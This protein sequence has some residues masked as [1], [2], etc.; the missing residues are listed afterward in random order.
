MAHF[1]SRLFTDVASSGIY[2]RKMRFVDPY[3]VFTERGF[4]TVWDCTDPSNPVQKDRE[5]TLANYTHDAMFVNGTDIHQLNG[6]NRFYYVYDMSD[7]TNLTLRGAISTGASNGS[8]GS[9]IAKQGNYVYCVGLLFGGT[10]GHVAI[11]NVSDPDNLSMETRFTDNTNLAGTPTGCAVD[12]TGKYLFVATSSLFTVLDI[13][14]A[15][16]VSYSNKVTITTG[17]VDYRRIALTADG[18][19]AYISNYIGD[20]IDIIDVSDPTSVSKVA[21]LHDATY[22]NG[23]RELQIVN[24][25]WLYS[26]NFGGATFYMSVWDIATDPTSPS[27]TESLDLTADDPW[28]DGTGRIGGFVVDDYANLYIGKYTT[29]ASMGF[30]S[31]GIEPA[32]VTGAP[33]NVAHHLLKGAFI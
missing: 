30:A 28:G 15:P 6:S 22:L 16:T 2:V 3:V 27:R 11:V 25:A 29:S 8:F 32:P 12:I 20:S 4:L 1:G 33:G 7:P 14:S 5:A 31:Y 10:W 19:Y 13:S 24:D 26:F 9:D 21:T 23:M 18:N 17:G